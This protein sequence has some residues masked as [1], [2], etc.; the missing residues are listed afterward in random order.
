MYFVCMYVLRTYIDHNCLSLQFFPTCMYV[1]IC[2][3]MYIH[4]CVFMCVIPFLT[5]HHHHS[6]HSHLSLSLPPF[7]LPFLPSP[8]YPLFPFSP[9]PPQL[10]LL[11]FL[12]T[13]CDVLQSG[14]VSPSLFLA[15]LHL[16][17][18]LANTPAA[19]H[20]CYT[21]LSPKGSR[22]FS[23]AE[24]QT[25]GGVVSWDHFFQSMKQYYLGLRQVRRHIHRLCARWQYPS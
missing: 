13:C 8:T 21:F 16:L 5:P 24:G 11:R 3:P 10:T 23:T 18:G 7:H 12:H 1:Y 14:R 15:F 4:I 22:G 17:Q 20:S 6:S 25:P 19:A 9:L 2:I